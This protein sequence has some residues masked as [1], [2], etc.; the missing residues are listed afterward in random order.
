MKRV[1]ENDTTYLAITAHAEVL[2][3]DQSYQQRSYPCSIVDTLRPWP[4]VDDVTSSRDFEG[5]DGE[6]GDG[7]L[8]GTGETEGGVDK[9]ADVHGKGAVDWVHDGKLGKGLHHEVDHNSDGQEANDHG[10]WPAGDK[11]WP[12]ADEETRANGAATVVLSVLRIESRPRA[13]TDI[14]I[15]CM[16]LPLR[17]RWSSFCW[18]MATLSTMPSSSD[19]RPLPSESLGEAL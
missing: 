7:I 13:N 14:A 15:I 12:R 9:A 3:G 1:G 18:P 16:C 2:N 8:P 17:L 11:G 5:K 19:E 10:R 4:V 6:P